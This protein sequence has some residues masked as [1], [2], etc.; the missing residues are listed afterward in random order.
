MFKKTSKYK[1]CTAKNILKGLKILSLEET[2]EEIINNNKSIPRF[3]NGEFRLIFGIS[4]AFQKK[5]N[6]FQ[7]D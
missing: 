2:L 1:K 7:K 6:Y 5:I 3:G 4:L